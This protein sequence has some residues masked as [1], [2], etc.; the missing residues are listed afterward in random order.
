MPGPIFPFLQL[1]PELRLKIYELVVGGHRLLTQQNVQPFTYKRRTQLIGTTTGFQAV[2]NHSTIFALL[3]VCHQI[4]HEAR[5]LPLTANTFSFSNPPSLDRFLVTTPTWQLEL[6]RNLHLESSI[7]YFIDMEH[8]RRSSGWAAERLLGLKELILDVELLLVEAAPS[9]PCRSLWTEAFGDFASLKL[10]AVKIR[11]EVAFVNFDF[12]VE[13]PTEEASSDEAPD[14]EESD[15]ET[16]DPECEP[17]DELQELAQEEHR[18][19][20]ATDVASDVIVEGVLKD[21]PKKA[22]Y[23]IVREEAEELRM[24]ILR[25]Q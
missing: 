25:L 18:I 21:V 2:V 8:W 19:H 14:M 9:G 13:D 16:P 20:S 7:A 10:S 5:L 3:R 15:E 11:V 1:P 17:G 6:I 23:R 12:E 4:Y 24:T 22:L